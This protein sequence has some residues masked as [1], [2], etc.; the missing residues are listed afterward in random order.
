M[1]DLT[2]EYHYWCKSNEFWQCKVRGSNGKTYTVLY[3][4]TSHTSR[5]A[6]DYSCDCHAFKF[7]KG[8]PCKHILQVKD[9]HCRWN[10]EAVCGSS[11]PAPANKLCPNCG[12]E[13]SVVK[14]GV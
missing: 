14:V 12:G 7:G 6:Y 1:P 10:W 13:L 4:Q 5:Y 3:S 11:A 2:I 8:K 9:Q